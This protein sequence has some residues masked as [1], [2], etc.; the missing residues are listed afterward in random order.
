MDCVK[1]FNARGLEMQ[2]WTG[3]NAEPT[4]CSTQ[5]P[6]SGYSH[7]VS[8]NYYSLHGLELRIDV[9]AKLLWMG[10]KA[11]SRS[12][13][14]VSI[15]FGHASYLSSK[16]GQGQK[17][18]RSALLTHAGSGSGDLIT[19]AVTRTTLASVAATTSEGPSIL[20]EL[21]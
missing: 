19:H 6:V 8:A 16:D 13:H 21:T 12:P 11:I 20:V 9:N 2:I 4:D 17:V 3:S 1:P 5:I 7:Y 10:G 14:V 15:S 18:T